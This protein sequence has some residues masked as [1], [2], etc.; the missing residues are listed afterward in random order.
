MGEMIVLRLVHV[1]GGIIW[2]GSMTYM[3]FFLMPAIADAGPA[4][5]RDRDGVQ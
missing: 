1:L 2:V 3:T 4:G 5:G